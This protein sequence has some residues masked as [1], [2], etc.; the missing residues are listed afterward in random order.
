MGFNMQSK[1]SLKWLSFIVGIAGILFSTIIIFFLVLAPDLPS[2]GIYTKAASIG[3]VSSG[4]PT[5]IRIPRINVDAVIEYVGLTPEGAMDVPKGPAEIGWFGLG[6]R[7][8][9]KGSAVMAGHSGWKNNIQAAFDNLYKLK[10]GDKIYVE[11]QTGATFAFVVQQFRTYG[12]NENPPEVFSSSDGKAHLNLITCTGA[13][14]EIARTHS[15][16]LAVFTDLE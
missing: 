4:T 16:R 3:Q 11:Y 12:P 10:K 7:P 14:N 1:I 9:E 8:G 6:Q 2:L 15:K 13:W 5:R